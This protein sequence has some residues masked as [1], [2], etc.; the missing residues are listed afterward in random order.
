MKKRHFYTF[1]LML[2]GMVAVSCSESDDFN[3][4][5]EQTKGKFNPTEVKF[6]K[7]SENMETTENWSNIERDRNNRITSYNYTREVKGYIN[8]KETRVCHIDYYTNHNGGENIRT[9]TDVDFYRIDNNGNEEK[10]TQSV[11]EK[12]EMNASGYITT[13]STTTDHLDSNSK[14]NAVTSTSE[15]RFTYNGD[16]CKESV[17]RDADMECVYKYNWN[18]YQLKSITVI[19]ENKKDN[20]TDYST[21]NYTFDKKDYYRYSPNEILPFV[22]SGFP[23]IFA[24]MGY[25]GKFTPYVLVGETQSGYTDYGDGSGARPKIEIRNTYNF[26]V[27]SSQKLCHSAL[28]NIYNAYS[29][30]L[31]K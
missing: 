1:L 12:I 14:G 9:R 29:V 8:E 15:R 5:N 10:Y 17:Y 4:F 18:A 25:L 2:A 3:P 28:S 30:T 20:T 21:Y 22:Q 7:S 26:D 13:I 16:L 19:K 6:Y 24:S 11:E 31:S 23:Q 27:D